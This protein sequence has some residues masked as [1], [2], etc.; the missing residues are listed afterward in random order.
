ML[1]IP[2]YPLLAVISPWYEIATILAIA[3]IPAVILIL[4]I[5]WIQQQRRLRTALPWF[6]RSLIAVSMISLVMVV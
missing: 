6:V 3:A 2:A 4:L 1:F 5:K